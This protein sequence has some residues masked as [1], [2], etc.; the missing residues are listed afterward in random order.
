MQ[1]L[2]ENPEATVATLF[3]DYSKA[4][5]K[6]SYVVLLEK[7]RK[8]KISG[9]LG[10][11]ILRWLTNRKMCVTIDGHKSSYLPVTSGVPE[12]SVAGP[13]PFKVM[14]LD[15]ATFKDDTEFLILSFADDT[16]LS[17]LLKNDKD[18]KRF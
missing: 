6:V 10:M 14:L 16:H 4:F 5:Q 12:G 9:L 11:W 17:R 7:L 3:I 13:E 1:Q 15:I 8:F 2:K 18:L